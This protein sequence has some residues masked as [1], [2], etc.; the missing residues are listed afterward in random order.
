MKKKII[1]TG[2]GLLILIS[3]LGGIKGL[4]IGRM[5][6]HGKNFSPPP[7]PV[8]TA[9]VRSET[10]ETKLTSVGSL[11]AVQGVTITAE[12]TGKIVNI[13]FEAGSKVNAG[14]LLVQQNTA[15]EEAQL[16]AAEAT[17]ALAKLTFERTKKLLSQNAISQ[18]E[19]DN[20]KSQ[21][22]QAT[23]H[24][25]EIRAVIAKK[26]VRAPFSGRLGIRMVNLGQVINE[27]EPIVSLQALDPI[28]VDFLLPQQELAQIR[29]GLTVRVTSDALP[30][31]SVE[32]TITAISP[33]VDAA[34]RNIRV[35]A[36]LSNTKE[37]LRPGMYVTAAVILPVPEEVLAIPATA[38]LY[39][40]Y[41]DSVFVV[42][43]KESEQS[44]SPTQVVEQQFIRLGERRGDYVAIASGLEEGQSVVS[45]GVF[46]LRNGQSVVVDNTLS[47]EFKLSPTPKDS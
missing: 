30:E 2:V 43:N 14:D 13:A 15:S 42:R 22:T 25:E 45:T 10:W 18:S 46:K 21:L 16:R 33:E 44:G 1:F 29:T 4:Q 20:A 23:A 8:T 17:E 31:A 36:T 34:T 5:V 39:A 35:Q 28:F 9:P 27:G 11:S 6:A 7:E 32:G 38:V 41:S 12:L 19:F 3:I 24:A 26:T 47:P 40:P 37:L